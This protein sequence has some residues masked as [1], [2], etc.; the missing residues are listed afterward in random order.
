VGVNGIAED[1]YEA[2]AWKYLPEYQ[3]CANNMKRLK[4]DYALVKLKDNPNI[5]L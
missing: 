3:T 2:E 4:F 1:Y 5:P